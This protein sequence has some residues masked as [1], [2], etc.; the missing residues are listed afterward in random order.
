LKILVA[1]LGT[2]GLPTAE[3]VA[4]AGLE[5]AGYDANPQAVQRAVTQGIAAT[6][7]WSDVPRADVFLVC[8]STHYD[9]TGNLAAVKDVDDVY[10]MIASM[11]NEKK[12]VSIESTVPPGTCRRIYET[13]SH[14]EVRLVHAPHRYWAG[15]P[16][17]YG[18]RQ[19]RVIAGIDNQSLAAGLDFY[20]RTLRIPMH[21]L[22]SIETAEMVKVAENAYRYVQIAYAQELREICDSLGI[23]FEEVRKGCN[24]KWNVE[25]L[26]AREGIGGHCLPKDIMYLSNLSADSQLIKA[27]VASNRLYAA[28]RLR[29][30][31]QSLSA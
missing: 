11:G 22:P 23:P 21:P 24:T 10:S 1:G 18:V 25:I 3:Y 12:L 20:E 4:T 28:R 29:E 27:A 8:V 9:E 5:V 17:N 15:D 6:T 31:S 7:S 16:V 14:R 2:V 30:G 26:E 13:T 19:P